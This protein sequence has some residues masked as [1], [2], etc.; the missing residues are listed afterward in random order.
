MTSTATSGSSTVSSG[1]QQTGQLCATKLGIA[2]ILP[3]ISFSSAS[4]GTGFGILAGLGIVGGVLLT[5]AVFAGV[6][7][8]SYGI[9]KAAIEPE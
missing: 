9:T 5:G 6:G 7:L 3:G 4:A 2:N 1:L 8:L